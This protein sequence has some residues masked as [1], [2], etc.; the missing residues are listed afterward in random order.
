MSRSR[1]SGVSSNTLHSIFDTQ[2]K[3]LVIELDALSQQHINPVNDETEKKV[4]E[5][6]SRP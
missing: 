4:T 5:S 1:H 2:E 3:P 6:A